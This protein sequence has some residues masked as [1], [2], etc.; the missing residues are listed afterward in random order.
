MTSAPDSFRHL[1]AE[2]QL[3]TLAL[4]TRKGPGRRASPT[5]RIQAGP[6]TPAGPARCA[7]A[8]GAPG[9]AREASGHG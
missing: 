2:P 7:D 1:P 4:M 5:R 8:G 6:W 9:T 3:V